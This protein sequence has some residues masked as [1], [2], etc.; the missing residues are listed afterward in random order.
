MGILGIWEFVGVVS[1][2][3]S[4]G[5]R[6]VGAGASIYRQQEGEGLGQMLLA[7]TAQARTVIGC[8]RLLLLGERGVGAS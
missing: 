1:L 5:V 3:S 4:W 7:H 8:S 2:N 6:R